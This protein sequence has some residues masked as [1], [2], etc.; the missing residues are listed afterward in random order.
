MT[1]P[2]SGTIARHPTGKKY[3]RRS[4]WAEESDFYP[5]FICHKPKLKLNLTKFNSRQPKTIT[6]DSSTLIVT[7][8]NTNS[9]ILSGVP[10]STPITQ[11]PIQ[12]STPFPLPNPTPRDKKTST[13]PALIRYGSFQTTSR[14]R[15]FTGIVSI[16]HP[17]IAPQTLTLI[18]IT[19]HLQTF[20][21]R[22]PPPHLPILVD[23]L[24]VLVELTFVIATTNIPEL[25][26]PQQESSF[27]NLGSLAN[28]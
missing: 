28:P 12:V 23:S 27:G 11:S 15:I 21:L 25:P 24:C 8:T 3:D 9:P 1:R 6:L 14:S 4:A 5:D 13:R 16:P 19:G 18:P 26:Q 20:S 10:P 17:G 7:T 2:S 22:L